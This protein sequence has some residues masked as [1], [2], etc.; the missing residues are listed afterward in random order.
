MVG[1]QRMLLKVDGLGEARERIADGPWG[2]ACKS[3][4]HFAMDGE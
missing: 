1:E 4:A 2:F 3:P